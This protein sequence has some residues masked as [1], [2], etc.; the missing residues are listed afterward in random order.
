MPAA[1]PV[2][3][4]VLSLH[5]SKETK[6]ILNAVEELGHGTEW[7]RHE[8][9]S[10][11][12]ADGQVELEPDVDI[13]A[14]RMLLSNT[15]QP[16]EELGLANTFAQ[17]VP[18]L[19]EPAT[20]LTAIHKLSTATTLAMA[21]VQTPDVVLAL[22]SD[23]LNAVR[24]QY[25]E[26]AVYKTAIGTHGGGTWKVGPGDPVNA[27]V[28]NR[29]AFLQELI[30]RDDERHRDVR[31]YVVDGEIIGAMYRYA[32]DNDWR[33]N[34]ALGGSVEN[35]TDDLPPAARELATQAADA[36]GLDYAGVDL[37]E[38]DEG[39]YVLEVN[40]TAGFKGLYEATEISPA[41]YIAKH[42]IESAGGSVDDDRVQE[43]SMKLDDS[44]PTAQPI[45]HTI[46]E[47]EPTVIG[48]TE[49]VVLSG[50]SGSTSVLAKSDTG[51]TRTSIDTGLAAE[52]GAGPIKSITR[53]KSGSRKTAR[54]RPV[55][56]V[57]VGVGGNQHTVTASIE[58]RDHMDYPVLLG[59]DILSNYRV[60]VGRRA[61]RD[62]EDR[63]EEE[64]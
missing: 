50:T 37:V 56:D 59:R 25:G 13:I 36:I 12:V 53:V 7:L 23:E 21:D 58:D 16:A 4:G 1:D 24:D 18:M 35:A 17:V 22:S 20:V 40:P 46:T 49:E 61:D 15:E 45:T 47:T 51:A 43:L 19:N 5:T 33:T 32:P 31:I 14:N 54:S 2:T 38:S 64:E 29:Y 42:A 57:V 55:V 44:Q 26:E 62:A 28:G 34:V 11:R 3:V 60:D 41:P 30:D 52:I 10:I 39:W 8:N 48:Y 6:A 9:T 27:K 63:P